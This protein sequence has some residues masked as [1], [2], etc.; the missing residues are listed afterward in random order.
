MLD[1]HGAGNILAGD[2]VLKPNIFT[3][4]VGKCHIYSY[5]FMCAN[6]KHVIYGNDIFYYS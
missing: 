6:D 1:E 5:I 2:D 4:R 3:V